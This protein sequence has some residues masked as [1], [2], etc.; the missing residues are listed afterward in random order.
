MNWYQEITLIDQDEISSYFIWSKVYTQ[1]HIAFAE[2]SNE[3]GKI[4][5]GV[6]F[7]QYRI[8]EH[9]KIGFLGTKIRVFANSENELRQLN[10]GKWLERLIDYV[11]IIQPREVPKTKI[12][13]YVNYYRVNPKMS[14]EERVVHQ[15]QRRNIS[16][17]EAKQHFKEYVEESVV[18]PYI[19]LK[20]LSAKREENV[21]RPYRLYIGKSIADEAKDGKFGTYGLSRTVTV[22]EF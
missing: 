10:L 19:N 12:T 8:N 4:C 20:S 1:L 16:L 15:A 13:S 21:D 11:H 9:K 18:E 22:P 2:H 5:F 17:D 6:S 7:P 3:Q 14:L